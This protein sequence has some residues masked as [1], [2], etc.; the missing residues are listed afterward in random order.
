MIS[1]VRASCEPVGPLQEFRGA[2]RRF[3]REHAAQVAAA[4]GDLAVHQTVFEEVEAKLP[5]R[6]IGD[7]AAV[8]LATHVEILLGLDDAHAQAEGLVDRRHPLGVAFG[9]VVVHRSEMGSAAGERVEHE[10]Q[11]GHERLA[12]ARL[13]LDDGAVHQCYACEQLHV[14]VP[15]AEPPPARLAGGGK[16]LDQERVGRFARPGPV[17]KRSAQPLECQIVERLH[18]GGKGLD[19][20]DHSPGG[21]I[22]GGAGADAEP[23]GYAVEPVKHESPHF[24]RMPAAHEDVAVSIGGV[25]GSD[26][27]SATRTAMPGAAHTPSPDARF[28][29]LPSLARC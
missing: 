20:G 26:K 12:F 4:F 5:G 15:H 8:G 7:I 1:G 14:V 16:A 28:G 17:G 18:L 19:A 22:D 2:A 27:C 23:R 25:S 3:A 13:H 21:G 9:E 10:R 6:A 29:I 11:C 24:R